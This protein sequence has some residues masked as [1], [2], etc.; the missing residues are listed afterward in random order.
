MRGL[1]YAV[2]RRPWLSSGP[3]EAGSGRLRLD[4]RGSAET[5]APHELLASLP[6]GA[7][8]ARAPSCPGPSVDR[9]GSARQPFSNMARPHPPSF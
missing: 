9:I 5:S 3:R 1:G 6:G 2:G 4:L 8:K 7:H